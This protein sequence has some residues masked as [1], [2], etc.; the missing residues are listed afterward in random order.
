MSKMMSTKAMKTRCPTKRGTLAKVAAL[1]FTQNMWS[2]AACVVFEERIC[3]EQLFWPIMSSFFMLTNFVKTSVLTVTRTSIMQQQVRGAR[4]SLKTKKKRTTHPWWYLAKQDAA[5]HQS[6][7]SKDNREYLDNV[8]QEKQ[9]R[10]DEL[11][12]KYQSPLNNESLIPSS[13]SRSQFQEEFSRRVGLIMK[14]IGVLPYWKKDGTRGLT[15]LLQL[16][17]NHVIKSYTIEH[18]AKQVVYQNRWKT[19]GLACVVMGAESQDPR[20]VTQAYAGLFREAG[21]LPKKKL[22]SMYVTEDALLPPGTPMNIHHFRVGDYVDVYGKTID[23]GFQGVVKR[24]EFKVKPKKGT[25]KDHRRPGSISRGRKASGPWKGK[26]MPGHMGNER[27][28]LPGLQILRINYKYNVIYVT[29]PAVPGPIGS[30]IYVYDSKIMGKRHT[31][32]NPPPFP[33]FYEG[34]DEV[35][36]LTEGQD[37]S[38]T[39]GLVTKP[40][41]IYHKDL[42]QFHSPTIV[43]ADDEADKKTIRTG[44]KLAK[45]RTKK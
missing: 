17:D 9:D 34:V 29:G 4:C 28:S 6:F 43:F 14:K 31:E 40:D 10:Q 26:K 44:A 42:H 35:K 11:A 30:W 7:L 38:T 19:D 23:H 13:E 15:T 24:W 32:R 39:T 36:E 41:C 33:T 5:K 22:T 27:R 2:S 20:S 12:K 21:V 1:V 16:I 8:I 3:F 25:T 45:V 18:Y 37:D